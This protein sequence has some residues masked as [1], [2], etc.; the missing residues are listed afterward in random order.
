[1]SVCTVEQP[2][3]RGAE[4]LSG[5]GWVHVGAVGKRDGPDRRGRHE[6]HTTKLRAAL[7]N[8]A[9]DHGD[10]EAGFDEAE[11]RVHLAPFDGEPWLKPCPLTGREGH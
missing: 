4:L 2:H 7:E 6:R 1:M 10:A 8:H 5:S 11:Y 9:G 3:Q